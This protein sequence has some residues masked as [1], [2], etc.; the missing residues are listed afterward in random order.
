M[1]YMKWPFLG[2]VAILLGRIEQFVSVF[3]LVLFVGVALSM[4]SNHAA[5]Q[6]TTGAVYGTVTDSDGAILPGATITARNVQT[7]EAQTV[8]TG[9]T[10]TYVF[11]SLMPGHYD[12]TAEI[13]GFQPMTQTG[14]DIEVSQ[15]VHVRFALRVG[16]SNQT[17]TVMAS[18]PLVDTRESQVGHTVEQKRIE[19]LPL[20]GRNAYDLVQT[21]PGVTNYSPAAVGGDQNGTQFNV[22]GN[23]ANANTFYLDGAFDSVVYR[24]GGNMIPNPNALQEFRLLTSNFDAEFGREPGGVV[25][26][27]TRSG[28][29]QF[30]GLVYDYLRNNVLNAKPYFATGVPELKQNQFGGNLGGP[31]LPNK[32]FFFFSY[33]GIRVRTPFTVNQ[34]SIV[35][36]TP[37]EA[38]GDFSASI[39][40]PK[41]NGKPC[42][43][44]PSSTSVNGSNGVI[45]PNQLDPVALALLKNVPLADPASG[46]TAQQR[47]SANNDG[48][49]YL[50]RI[51]DQLTASHKI[52]ATFFNSQTGAA[53]PN[54]GN[55]Q[56]LT[57]SGVHNQANQINAIVSDTWILSANK[58]N[59]LRLFYTRN[60]FSISNLHDGNTWKDLGS[61]IMQGALPATQPQIAITGYWS[62]GSGGSGPDDLSQQALGAIDTYDWVSQNH[63]I[64]LGGS[65]VWNKF[66]EVGQFLGTGKLSFTGSAAG[67]P[68]S[69]GNALADFLVGRAT[70]FAQNSGVNHHLHAPE[71]A[72]FAQDDYRIARNVTLNL[73][74]RWELF[75]AFKGQ[76]NLGTF[77]PNVQS[78]RFP[79]APLGLL[80]SGD[81]GVPDGIRKL[82][83]TKFAPRIGFAYDIFGNGMASLRGAYGIFYAASQET[84]TGN[85]E[86]QPFLLS[87]SISATPNL[88]APYG[89]G[90]DPYPYSVTT[91]TFQ[92]NAIIAGLAPGASVPYVQEYNLTA[93]QQWGVEW[94]TQIAYIGSTSRKFY[95][96]RD[97]N[98]P[99][100]APD[101]K[102]S[103]QGLNARRPYQPTPGS[104]VFGQISQIDPAG[105]ASYN[106]LQ[107]SISHRLSHGFSLQASYV[108]SK[109]IDIASFDPSNG[110]ALSLVDENDL[111]RDKGPAG[112]NNGNR[113]VASYLYQLPRVRSLGKVGEVLLNGWQLNGITTLSTGSPFNITSGVD[114]NLDGVNNDR[115]NVI[116]NPL[117]PGGRS[118]AN[119]IARYFNTDAF[120]RV[121]AGVPYGNAARNMLTGPGFI[122]TDLSV[123]KQFPIWKE[124]L[125]QLRGEI[126]NLFNNVNLSNPGGVLGSEKFGVISDSGSPRIV[127]FALRYSF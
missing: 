99:V 66:D 31:I 4:V 101:G 17:V 61:S 3:A 43:A 5:A 85:L 91:P 51:D 12:V 125:L 36:P 16:A 117:L 79:N 105:N 26:V 14:L 37:A 86:Q 45:C 93:Q 103:T 67:N 29:N 124:G 47:A 2:R 35:T 95:I 127:Q 115:P 11:P 56:I 114:S 83:W 81:P 40:K 110:S 112:T 10:G 59:S 97:Q 44:T 24:N 72:L 71:P 73:G 50:A 80:S 8:K 46:V 38:K 121:P 108:W 58:L 57:Y 122:D 100:Y 32:L 111:A 76:N 63:S 75:P 68:A 22:N 109:S 27:I 53:V 55:N 102:T 82:S 87:T 7:G 126:F 104:Y 77:V 20:N 28:T 41:L 118:R 84:L 119:K 120:V 74:V 94:S 123:F 116:A 113:F 89:V 39:R 42:T 21:V 62:M 1:T 6:T 64:K 69:T 15:N 106:S 98:S 88:T 33:E 30:H 60:H 96:L 92:A 9:S 48:N 19:D 18:T 78:T 52:S 49:Q 65:F 90:R 34:G 107:V 70:T 25:N 23:R 54:A 13:Q